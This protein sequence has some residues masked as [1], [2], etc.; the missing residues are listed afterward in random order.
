MTAVDEDRAEPAAGS[1]LLLD[2]DPERCAA[3]RPALDEDAAER[4]PLAEVVPAR[5]HER[6]D[7]YIESVLLREHRNQVRRGQ[8][9][10]SDQDLAEPPARRR[11]HGERLLELLLVHDPSL[12]QE[13]TEPAPRKVARSRHDAYKFGRN[14]RRL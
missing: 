2:R 8:R 9:A 13:L 12:D 14:G 3:E 5:S 7:A 4:L 6:T 1:A 10:A 11:L